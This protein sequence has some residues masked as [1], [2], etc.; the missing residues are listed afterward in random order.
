MMR[1]A[2]NRG[3]AASGTRRRRTRMDIAFA[4]AL[5]L[6]SVLALEMASAGEIVYQPNNPSFGGFSGNSS[7][8]YQ[9]A[10]IHNN[11]K[12]KKERK[13]KLLS[14]SNNPFNQDPIQ[15]FSRTLQS[16]LLSGL[17]DQIT[18]AIYGD[19]PQ[20]SGTFVVNGTTVSFNTVGNTVYLTVSDG[21][22]VT[23]IALPK[24]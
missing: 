17:A 19:N 10:E 3:A 7:H 16:R 12:R 22:S 6:A 11:F 18:T 1:F 15:E 14:E 9:G 8:L 24:K 4:I 5:P 2:R 13:E 20:G 21:I 23:Q